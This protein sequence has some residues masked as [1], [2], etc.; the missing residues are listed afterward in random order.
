MADLSGVNI[1]LTDMSGATVVVPK[2][3]DLSVVVA[4]VVKDLSGAVVVKDLSGAVVAKDLSGAVVAVAP[5]SGCCSSVEK[6]AVKEWNS[7]DLSGALVVKASSSSCCCSKKAVD[8]KEVTAKPSSCCCSKKAVDVK[9]V[10]AKSS[11]CCCSKKAVDVLE[12]AKDLSGST[13]V[14][15]LSGVV[16]TILQDLSGAS[17]ND[18][19]L[20]LPRLLAAAQFAGAADNSALVKMKHSARALLSQS[21]KGDSAAA[22]AFA[23][24]YLHA[25]CSALLLVAGDKTAAT[26]A[27]APVADKPVIAAATQEV[28]VIEKKATA[29]G[30]S[31]FVCWNQ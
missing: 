18:V 4:P 20:A 12:V 31:W 10:T 5:S 17:V 2:A 22:T 8:V 1:V 13:I 3:T 9:E 29:G 16:S 14:T 26:A 23:D 30:R 28:K 6:Q 7:K 15:D 19:I 24:T 11:S 21:V 25:V 27:T